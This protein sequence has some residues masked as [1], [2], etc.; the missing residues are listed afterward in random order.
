MLNI[1]ING[2]GKCVFHQLIDNK[3]IKIKTMNVPRLFV[4]N[5]NEYINYD[6]VHHIKK[7]KLNIKNNILTISNQN[8]KLLSNREIIK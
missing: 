6:S 3:H 4:D 7:R 8:I 1:G 5:L 2:F